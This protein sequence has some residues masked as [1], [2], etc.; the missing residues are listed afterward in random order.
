MNKIKKFV[1]NNKKLCL[2]ISAILV[3]GIVLLFIF[4]RSNV[5]TIRKV[6]KILSPN[7]YSVDCLDENCEYITASKGDKLGKYTTY[8]YDSNGKKIAKIND[9]YNSESKFVKNISGVNKNYV[10]FKKSDYASGKAIGYTLATT[11]GKE[12]Y[13]SDGVLYGLTDNLISEKLDDTYKIIDL[14]G[15]TVF[16]NV[17]D[18]EKYADNNILSLTVKN[19]NIITDSKGKAILNGY[20]IVSEVKDENDKTLYFVLEDS[21][22][23][24]YYCFS[25]AKNKIIGDSFNGYTTGSNDGELIITK[26][27]NGSS[28]KYILTKDGKQKEL[29]SSSTKEFSNKIKDTFSDEDYSLYSDSIKLN[30]Q[31][32]VFVNNVKK[33]TFGVLDIASK[34]YT[35]LLD[36]TA[37]KG[38]VT[39]YELETNDKE[40]YLQVNCSSNMCKESTMIVYDMIN[41]KELY[42]TSDKENVAQNYAQY[43]DYKVIKYSLTSSDDYKGKYVL[44]NNKN[45]E[46][47]KSSNQ[48]V[49]IDKEFTFGKTPS[50][51]S[52]ILFS[53]KKNKAL[54]NDNNLASKIIIN[55]TFVYK[56]SDESKT[57]LLNSKGK[58]LKELGNSSAS[59]IYSK[60]AIIYI[61]NNRVFIVNPVDNKT[62]AYKLK[63]NEK[64]N[65]NSGENIA[66]YKNGLYI[67]NTVDNYFKVVNVKGRQIKKV[68]NSSIDKV[69]YNK[70]NN[71]VIIISK[72]VKDNNNLYGLY[73]AK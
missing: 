63:N 45:K 61:E 14:K 25:Y 68:K 71:T 49:V 70:K 4:G 40:V 36:F 32:V 42:R 24:A 8:I 17:N 39:I 21:N 27:E 59:L 23:N 65:D 34:K 47:M 20:R 19:E 11:K 57:Y 7:F 1:R 9:K 58:Q 15:K 52:L 69:R 2:I 33:N 54:N 37:E 41:N 43:E 46:V 64:I 66:P 60:D 56:Y 67:N 31:K 6:K 22:K 13:S 73:I 5:V 12:K 50:N 44:Y 51:Q 35:K 26:N 38:S 3:I 10:I 72:R 62:N 29:S 28:K 55:T 53:A 16:G 30:T 18:I 48:I